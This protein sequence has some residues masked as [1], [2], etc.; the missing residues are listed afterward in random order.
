[1]TL[2]SQNRIKLLINSEREGFAHSSYTVH[3]PSV[4]AL[5][6]RVDDAAAVMAR[7]K[8]LAATPFR[9]NVLEGELDIPAIRGVGGSLIYFTDDRSGLARLWEIDFEASDPPAETGN[10]GLETIDHI[11]QSMEY[12]EM[13]SWLL[14][15]SAI[16]DVAKTPSLDIPDPGGLVRSLVVQNADQSVSLVLNGSQSQ[17]TASARFL[18]EFFRVRCPAHRLLYQRYS[19]DGPRHQSLRS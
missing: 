16:F 6:L 15:Y 13:L 7:A 17:H 8:A 9:Q 3:G 18:S 10:V 5:C 12:D 2:W 11:A 14:F 4:C 1:M 19:E